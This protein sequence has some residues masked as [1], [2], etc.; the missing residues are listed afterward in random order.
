MA[1]PNIVNV[2][3]ITGK[4]A[5]ALLTTSNIDMIT[6]S[7]GSGKVF[8]VNSF[9]V[10]NVNGAAA[11]Q[12]TVSLIRNSTEYKVASTIYVP[13]NSTL[14]VLAKDA[15]F[16]MEEGDVL[17]AVASANNFLHAVASYESIS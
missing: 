5:V 15:A 17:R 9:I 11:A 12:V 16:Y 2:S 10:S 8:K 1:A 6:N 13:A 3:N 4:T 14:V 7:S